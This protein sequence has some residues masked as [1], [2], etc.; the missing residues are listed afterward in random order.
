MVILWNGRRSVIYIGD[1][2]FTGT[3]RITSVPRIHDRAV[4]S[5]PNVISVL[6]EF[7]VTV[8]SFRVPAKVVMIV[9]DQDLC[10][11]PV[12]LPV[13]VSRGES[14][15]PAANHNEI[16]LFIQSGYGTEVRFAIDRHGVGILI[17]TRMT[18]AQRCSSWRIVRR[19]KRFQSVRGLGMFRQHCGACRNECSIDKVPSSN[20][21]HQ[22]F[23]IVPPSF[24]FG[25]SPVLS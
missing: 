14:A 21:V 7:C 12:L 5:D 18:S 11:L 25:H 24:R 17:R 19:I 4:Q 2:N 15:D 1:K 3:R 10:V 6:V 20:P 22:P 9:Q 16:V 8:C 13:I 23:P